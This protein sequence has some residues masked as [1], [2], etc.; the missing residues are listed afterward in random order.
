MMRAGIHVAE[1]PKE[2]PSQRILWFVL[3]SPITIM[4]SAASGW[5]WDR[6]DHAAVRIDVRQSLLEAPLRGGPTYD[7]SGKSIVRAAD[8]RI[9]NTWSKSLRSVEVRVLIVP[10]DIQEKGLPS[11]RFDEKCQGDLPRL[12]HEGFVML[13][14]RCEFMQPSEEVRLT[15]QFSANQM[16]ALQTNVRFPEGGRQR[17]DWHPFD[18]E[19]RV[20]DIVQS[21]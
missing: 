2:T 7:A 19:W 9:R 6:L 21:I 16:R 8:V 13:M 14:M 20:A 17:P 4:L 11:V 3:G 12:T 18:R 15:I 5:L 1:E 10:R